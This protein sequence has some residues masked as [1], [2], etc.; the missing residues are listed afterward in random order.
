MRYIYTL[1]LFLFLA[2]AVFGQTIAVS[3]LCMSGT[4]TL[5]KTIDVEGKVAYE[6]TGTVA[7]T[8]GVAVSVF[9]IG[10]PDNVW[11][12][13]F[14]GQPY[15]QSPCDRSTP[16]STSNPSCPWSAVPDMPCT[17][18]TALSITGTGTLP[19]RLVSFTAGKSGR[20]VQ[21][22]WQTASE[23]NN[24]GFDVQR[25]KNGSD[26]TT[27]GFVA[28]GLNAAAGQAYHFEDASPLSGK[29]FYRLVQYDLDNR[30][31]QSSVVGVD[32]SANGFY[33]LQH[34]GNGRYQLTIESESPVELSV[35]DLSGRKLFG[36]TAGQGVHAIDLSAFAK[37]IYLLQLK[38]D[39]QVLTEKLIK[40]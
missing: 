30:S 20:Q 40:Q 18:G 5:N 22:N 10:A 31:T 27:I 37:G 15:F 21:L 35:V 12:L 16:P 11:V 1:F 34:P 23:T 38:K 36:K 24:R 7:G 17:G 25:S 33:T 3:G 13:A 8:A 14:D 32:F 28:A 19:V 39:Q 6:G 26:W 2:S 4:I 9:W 29:N